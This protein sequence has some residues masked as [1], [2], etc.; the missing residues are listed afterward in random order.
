MKPRPVEEEFEGALTPTSGG[1]LIQFQHLGGGHPALPTTLMAPVGFQVPLRPF[2]FASLE[3]FSARVE[4]IIERAGAVEQLRPSTQRW[5][6]DGFVAFHAFLRQRPRYATGFLGGDF[7][8]QRE[9]LIQW[10]AALITRGVG[11]VSVRTY[12]GAMKAICARIETQDALASPL[13]WIPPPR[14]GRLLPKSLPRD[15]A[16]TIMDFVQNYE[17]HSSFAK[18]RNTAIVGTMLL[19][20]LRSGEVTRLKN[21]DVDEGQGTFRINAGKGR[22]GGKDRTA[23]MPPYL[24]SLIAAY[25][26]ERLIQRPTAPNFF[27]TTRTDRPFARGSMRDLFD[28]I[29]AK[30]GIRVSPHRLR[31]TYATLLRQSG[32]PDRVSMDLL[33]HAQLSTLQR[34]SAVFDN[35]YPEAVKNLSLD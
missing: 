32:I 35:E 2:Q 33:G 1:N 23:Y 12:W 26:R 28:V 13:R 6:K 30:T 22:D 17:W 15:A 20:G 27:V 5:M 8:Q 21:D 10:C 19:A 31:H 18:R 16:R 9:V 25:R 29:S 4:S 24:K 11:R 14:S 34:Y 3:H 7:V